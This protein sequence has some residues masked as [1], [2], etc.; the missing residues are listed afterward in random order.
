MAITGSEASGEQ[1]QYSF[2]RAIG[3]RGQHLPWRGSDPQTQI[4]RDRSCTCFAAETF[5]CVWILRQ[6]L[7]E[8]L[9]RDEAPKLSVLSLLDHAHAAAEFLDNA[10]ARNGLASHQKILGFR[11]ASSY[12]RG[13]RQS[14]KAST[15]GSW[16]IAIL[17]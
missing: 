14:T 16:P 13:I 6:I 3:T 4:D 11:G 12:G 10:I 9:Q 5:Q 8:K 17:S 7:G 1:L 2:V 15:R